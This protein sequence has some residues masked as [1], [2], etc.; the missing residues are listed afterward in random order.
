MIKESMIEGLV[1]KRFQSVVIPAW[2]KFSR[3]HLPTVRGALAKGLKGS[4]TLRETK[5]L[6]VG[7]GK[8][9]KV[10]FGLEKD[11][12]KATVDLS[13][14]KKD[15]LAVYAVTNAMQAGT[16]PMGTWAL[17]YGVA[18][19]G[20]KRAFKNIKAS[21]KKSKSTPM[22]KEALSKELMIRAGKRAGE[23]IGAATTKSLGHGN[24][25]QV[26]GDSITRSTAK[27]NFLTKGVGKDDTRKLLK[28]M[29]VDR[30]QL[31]SSPKIKAQ[32]NHRMKKH[33]LM[34]KTSYLNSIY[35]NAFKK[36]IEILTS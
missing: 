6:P 5:R 29:L 2:K 13:R 24:P 33:G 3:K 34:E 4:R 16:N 25:K 20:T 22:V 35:D 27:F 8:S 12:Y 28:E 17:G 30:K 14:G 26:L 21:M 7:F 15:M 9:V 32:M 36:E 10:P 19:H 1:P 11:L 18:K 31:M 23:Y